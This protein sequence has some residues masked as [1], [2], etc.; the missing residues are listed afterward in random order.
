M[1]LRETAF[2]CELL[3]DLKQCVLL[4][5]C[6]LGIFPFL[7][8]RILSNT[9]CSSLFL[10]FM[11]HFP[12]THFPLCRWF[13]TPVRWKKCLVFS[14]VVSWSFFICGLIHSH[15][16]GWW[17]ICTYLCSGHTTDISVTVFSLFLGPVTAFSLLCLF[18]IS[19]PSPPRLWKDVQCFCFCF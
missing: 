7:S 11:W 3:T 17:F 13:K 14:H 1:R 4:I 10:V 16:L 6:L 19:L 5:N 18:I 15:F 8:F 9:S 2:Q 12:I